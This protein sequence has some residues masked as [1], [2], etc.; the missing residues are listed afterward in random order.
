MNSKLR[1]VGWLAVAGLLATALISPATA[2]ATGPN[3]A[4]SSSSQTSWE[5]NGYPID[6]GCTS[7]DTAP[8]EVLWIF[9]GDSDS[10]VVLHL[11]G[12]EYTG[13]QMGKG[14]AWHI[15]SPWFDSAPTGAYVTWTGT[16][17][18]SDKFVLTISHGCEGTTTTTT[19]STTSSETTSETTSD[20]TSSETT[21]DT[22]TSDTT[23]S[24]TTTS[25]TTSSTT[26]SE[27]TS[28]TTDGT[29][30]TSTTT[31][32]S[33]SGSVLGET[34][35]PNVT[36]PSTDTISASGGQSLGGSWNML[37]VLSAVLLV[38]V[39]ILTPAQKS[40]RNK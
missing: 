6:N 5:G 28:T 8:G 11:N 27:T 4:A 3:T 9:S 24:D 31:K 20:T 7:G 36:P 37:L 38:A 35:T 33:P 1:I 2:L 26:S 10:D 23:T 14:G 16:F 40:R 13:T 32:S 39:L 25:D 22:T 29:T 18:N 12:S 15:I 21:S 34:G 19:S 30:T 17:E